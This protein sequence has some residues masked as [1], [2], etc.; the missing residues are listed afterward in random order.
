[1]KIV[2]SVDGKKYE[3]ERVVCRGGNMGNGNGKR[4]VAIFVGFPRRERRIYEIL[5]RTPPSLSFK[6]AGGLAIN[7]GLLI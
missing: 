6:D 1:M 5:V 7:Q 4:G 2:E 3:R